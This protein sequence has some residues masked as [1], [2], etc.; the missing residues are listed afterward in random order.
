MLL[1][2]L[3]G[4]DLPTVIVSHRTP[5]SVPGA[6][7]V[8]VPEGA[9]RWARAILAVLPGQV[10]AFQLATRRHVDLDHPHGLTKVTLTR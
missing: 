5:H 9:P 2:R 10:A 7:H 4:R 8:P 3:G 6:L 1:T